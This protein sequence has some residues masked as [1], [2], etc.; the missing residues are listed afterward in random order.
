MKNQ[1]WTYVEYQALASLNMCREFETYI[2]EGC[3]E[4]ALNVLREK[5]ERFFMRERFQ[6]LASAVL[7]GDINFLQDVLRCLRLLYSGT[8]V[9]A[10]GN[11]H[12]VPLF[13]SQKYIYDYLNLAP[14]I[15]SI[16]GASAAGLPKLSS[17]YG[18]FAKI[19]A[20]MEILRPK[21]TFLNF[22]QV[23]VEIGIYYKNIIKDEYIVAADFFENIVD[24]YVAY[25]RNLSE[26][27]CLLP[28]GL[29]SIEN[30]EAARRVVERAILHNVEDLQQRQ[31]A[32]EK[33]RKTYPTYEQRI[34]YASLYNALLFDKARKYGVD[35][36]N[37]QWLF[38]KNNK[39]NKLWTSTF[40]PHYVT[41]KFKKNFFTAYVFLKRTLPY[42]LRFFSVIR[43]FL[44]A[45]KAQFI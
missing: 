37:T 22:G 20:T 18:L 21:I 19:Q 34:K 4:Q 35:T 5:G 11:S 40:D 36:L 26:R 7:Y 33:L 45:I 1:V 27:V 6:S 44:L 41:G 9:C 28:I 31:E 32:T 30:D 17:T 38:C 25:T 29:P 42:P 12:L 23:D 43:A 3:R 16:T 8:T 2:K 10:W 15:F 13:S 14:F 39:V 24:G